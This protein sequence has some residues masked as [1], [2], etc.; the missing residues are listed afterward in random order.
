MFL[1]LFPLELVVFPGENLKLHIFEPRYVQLITECNEHQSTFGIPAY[2]DG[3]LATHGTVMKL[4]SIEN[5]YETGE[6]DIRTQGLDVFH[7]DE[8]V[9]NVPDKLYYGGEVSIIEN[10]AA[11]YPVTYDELTAQYARLHEVLKTGLDE[12]RLPKE[13]PSFAVGQEIGLDIKIKLHLL[14][15]SKESDRQLIIIDYLHKVIPEIEK[16]DAE[17]TLIRSN[18]HFKKLPAIDL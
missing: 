14:A 6:M 12:V 15:T 11:Y 7:L 9:R 18:G 4:V 1:P 8:F 17:R 5:S 13:N 10:D 16:A 2:F 3:K